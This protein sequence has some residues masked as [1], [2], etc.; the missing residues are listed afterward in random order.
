MQKMLS[1]GFLKLCAWRA[2]GALGSTRQRHGAKDGH[3]G[4]E[5]QRDE[6]KIFGFFAV[7]AIGQD[8]DRVCVDSFKHAAKTG[9]GIAA[10]DCGLEAETVDEEHLLE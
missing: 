5:K 9:F 1:V 6:V 2:R 4:F 8:L 3:C 10:G 7:H